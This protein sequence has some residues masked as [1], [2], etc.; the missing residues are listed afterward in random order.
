MKKTM[1]ILRKCMNI[2]FIRLIRCYQK[3]ISKKI[4]TCQFNQIANP[5]ILIYIK[6]YDDEVFN[7][8]LEIIQ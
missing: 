1:H 2:D 8:L 5:R 4:R 3:P 6:P 7:A